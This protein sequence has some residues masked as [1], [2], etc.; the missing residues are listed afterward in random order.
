MATV[1]VRREVHLNWEQVY[2]RHGAKLVS[3]EKTLEKYE[4]Q[5]SIEL[6]PGAI[7]I[8]FVPI[9]EGLDRGDEVD[10]AKV[11]ET[12]KRVASEAAEN[13]DPRDQGGRGRSAWSVLRAIWSQWCNLPPICR[14]T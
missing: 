9:V 2:R 1:V 14:E 12:F 13:P 11:E 7:E 10:G 5:Y 8:L 4:R 6:S 3:F